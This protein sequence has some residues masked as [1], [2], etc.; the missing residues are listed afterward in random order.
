M[1][2]VIL[3]AAV[4]ALVFASCSTQPEPVSSTGNLIEGSFGNYDGRMVFLERL[5]PAGTVLVD[6]IEVDEE[7][8]FKLTPEIP[9]EA[10]YR[11]IVQD[12]NFCRLV[13][14]PGDSV[15]I[16]ADVMAL[17]PTYV[18]EGSAES[19][20]VAW[21]S[22]YLLQYAAKMDSIEQI[23][24]NAQMQ[25][26]MVTMQNLY[27]SQMNMNAEAGGKM[28]DFINEA[29]SA[30]SSLVAAQRFNPA[31]DFEIYSRVENAM[32]AE[33]PNSPYLAAL[34]NSLDRVRQTQIG[35]IPPN[36]IG[37]N[38]EG[39]QVSLEDQRGKIVLLDFWASWCR[40]CRAEN[41]N[42]VAAY[43]KYNEKGFEIFSVSLDEKR[44]AWVQAIKQDQMTWEHV[45]DLG[46]WQSGPAVLYNITSIPATFLLDAEGRIIAKN[47]RGEALHQKLEELL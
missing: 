2:R 34:S 37:L 8:N 17:E 41:P 13:L 1:K 11:I 33:R 10:Y 39:E 29:P 16:T 47:L 44:N 23:M 35:S 27:F 31:D 43:K 32:K 36:I 45:S 46:G 25:G 24:R 40:P 6:T 21:L 18:V 38:P 4:S 9:E 15:R 14:Q 7:G 30:L 42:V 26:D 22:Q 20:R 12:N 19:R 3:L 28:N 5:D